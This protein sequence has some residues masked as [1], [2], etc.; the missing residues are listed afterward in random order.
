MMHNVLLKLI[1]LGITDSWALDCLNISR[2]LTRPT[3][4]SMLM[5]VAI[6]TLNFGKG[7]EVLCLCNT[8]TIFN[9]LN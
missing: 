2:K 3:S 4:Y 6:L 9:I 8:L 5:I 7:G 1:I